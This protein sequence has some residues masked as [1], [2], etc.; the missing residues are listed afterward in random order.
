M[1][2]WLNGKI[3][4]VTAWYVICFLSSSDYWV[5]INVNKI[6]CIYYRYIKSKG[7]YQ[8][9]NLISNGSSRHDDAAQTK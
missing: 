6:V 5:Y 9:E 3:E 2:S 8:P 7:I 1:T 4:N